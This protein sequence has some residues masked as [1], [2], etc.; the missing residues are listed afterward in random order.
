VPRLI[1]SVLVD[2]VGVLLST[3]SRWTEGIDGIHRAVC[4][5]VC[6]SVAMAVSVCVCM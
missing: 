4:L 2:V 6:L 5:C 1:S 3:M